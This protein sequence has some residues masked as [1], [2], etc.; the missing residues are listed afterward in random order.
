MLLAAGSLCYFVK[1]AN[2]F[3]DLIDYYYTFI[4]RVGTSIACLV[5]IFRIDE[6]NASYADRRY[7]SLRCVISTIRRE[8]RP[9]CSNIESLRHGKAVPPPFNKG[10]LMFKT[11]YKLYY[12]TTA[13]YL[14]YTQHSLLVTVTESGYLL[15]AAVFETSHFTIKS[16]AVSVVPF[17]ARTV[18]VASSR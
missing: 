12:F 3:C 4:H 7:R 1:Y 8:H 11:I 17:G 9:R 18:T 13:V 6:V 14:P 15:S 5:F 10:G 16:D 2:A